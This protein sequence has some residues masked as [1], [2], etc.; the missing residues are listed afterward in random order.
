MKRIHKSTFKAVLGIT[1]RM[2]RSPEGV[3]K[4]AFALDGRTWRDR[5]GAQGHGGNGIEGVT[6][7]G[8]WRKRNGKGGRQGKWRQHTSIETL[9]C[10]FTRL[11]PVK[12]LK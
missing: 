4:V 8:S 10:T 6:E 2:P 1:S 12:C 5:G 11:W 7:E 3:L 9:L